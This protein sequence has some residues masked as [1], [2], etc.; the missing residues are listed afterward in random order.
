RGCLPAAALTMEVLP[1]RP[2]PKAPRRNSRWFSVELAHCSPDRTEALFLMLHARPLDQL[3]P[4][5][6]DF[7]EGH[8]SRN[9]APARVLDYQRGMM[10]RRVGRAEGEEGG[11]ERRRRGGAQPDRLSGS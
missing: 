11:Y 4:G 6:L 9:D 7:R 8:A 3:E 5:D 2:G 1:V 10:D